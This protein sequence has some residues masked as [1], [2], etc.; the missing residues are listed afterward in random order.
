[1]PN[2]SPRVAKSARPAGAAKKP[3][4]PTL[5]A[6]KPLLLAAAAAGVGLV[7]LSSSSPDPAPP[8]SPAVQAAEDDTRAL[9]DERMSLHL[10]RLR[11]L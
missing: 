8:R 1:M 4:E 11:D 10:Q 2:L 3:Q 6:W 5:P 9:V 7:A